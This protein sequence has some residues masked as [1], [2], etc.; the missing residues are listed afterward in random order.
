MQAPD[1][2]IAERYTRRM[3]LACGF[4]GDLLQGDYLPASFTCPSCGADLY[5]RPPKAYSEL[6]DLG[7]AR[8][9]PS[10]PP[11]A[12]AKGSKRPRRLLRML[13][14]GAAALSAA[15]ALTLVASL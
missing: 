15:A 9:T 12:L 14:F 10:A 6:E 7:P 1:R 11:R 4:D 5:A 8:A 2:V 3:C 13:S